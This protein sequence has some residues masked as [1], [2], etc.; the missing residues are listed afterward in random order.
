VVCQQR[1]SYIA[2]TQEGFKGVPH[3]TK[4]TQ[5]HRKTT[6]LWSVAVNRGDYWMWCLA[7]QSV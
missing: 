4:K 6:K 2:R 5:E 7:V 1:L 3:D